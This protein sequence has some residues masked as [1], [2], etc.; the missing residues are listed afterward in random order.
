MTLI[1][2]GR[3]IEITRF[4]VIIYHNNF[5]RSICTSQP[6]SYFSKYIIQSNQLFFKSFNSLLSNFFLLNYIAFLATTSHQV[7]VTPNFGNNS[8]LY[9]LPNNPPCAIGV[10]SEVLSSTDL[11]GF[12]NLSQPT[13]SIT[14]PSMSWLVRHLGICMRT[15][16]D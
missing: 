10:L 8:T 7:P 3:K 13:Y 14:L 16:V 4:N 2:K 15:L 5:K 1:H 9:G 6:T 11:V 12:F